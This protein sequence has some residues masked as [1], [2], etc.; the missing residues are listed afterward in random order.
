MKVD[1]SNNLPVPS[2]TNMVRR[3]VCKESWLEGESREGR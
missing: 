2:I 3:W 1:S